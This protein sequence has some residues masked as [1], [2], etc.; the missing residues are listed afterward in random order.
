MVTG[1]NFSYSSATGLQDNKVSHK[2]ETVNINKDFDI[3]AELSTC[4]WR[5]TD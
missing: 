2:F 5:E 4:V 3:F 1:L